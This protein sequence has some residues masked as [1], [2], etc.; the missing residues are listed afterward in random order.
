MADV[1]LLIY[2]H[3]PKVKD[4]YQSFDVVHAL[5]H[6][7]GDGRSYFSFCHGADPSHPG[8]KVTDFD[9]GILPWLFN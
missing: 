3:W 9:E 1:K 2:F 5:R 4:T 6:R 7:S 8:L